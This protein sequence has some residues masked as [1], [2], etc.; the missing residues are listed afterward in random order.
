MGVKLSSK[1]GRGYPTYYAGMNLLTQK[2]KTEY[3]ILLTFWLKRILPIQD[4][5][6]RSYRECWKQLNRKFWE[7]QGDHKDWQI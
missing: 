7:I 6:Q 1:D 5:R 3:T 2:P 4:Q